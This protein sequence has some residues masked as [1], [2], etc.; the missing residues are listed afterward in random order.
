MGNNQQCIVTN[1]K[2]FVREGI[3]RG[4]TKK[5]LPDGVGIFTR[6]SGDIYKGTYINGKLKKGRCLYKN[7]DFYTGYW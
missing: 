3:Y 6:K 4:E 2:L 7:Q 5:G 1:E